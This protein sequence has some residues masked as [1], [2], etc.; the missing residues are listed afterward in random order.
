[1]S[2]P[3]LMTSMSPCKLSIFS[4]QV[5]KRFAAV[6]LLPELPPLCTSEVN[7]S[8]VPVFSGFASFCPD[9][10][11]AASASASAFSSALMSAS[12]SVLTSAS[13]SVLTSALASVLTS[14]LASVVL[15]DGFD[16]S[17]VTS[18]LFSPSVFSSSESDE[19]AS[20]A[21][22]CL[23]S[24]TSRASSAGSSVMPSSVSLLNSIAASPSFPSFA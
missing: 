16:E 19:P 14:A 6:S 4:I 5:P 18:V 3:K 11:S 23:T 21:S 22:S 24:S 12:A 10:S 15:R 20:T 17:S 1:M 2:P 7:A 9:P 13:A 8:T